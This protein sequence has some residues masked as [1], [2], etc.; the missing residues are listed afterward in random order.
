[1]L[2]ELSANLLATRIFEA[3][4][5]VTGFCRECKR[6]KFQMCEKKTAN[7]IFRNG[8]C[9]FRK[10]TRNPD[11]YTDQMT[12]DAEY[13]TLRREATVSVPKDVDPVAYCPLLCAGVTCFN[14]LRQQNITAGELVAVQGIGGLGHL[15][16]QYAAKLGYRVVVLSRGKDK[17]A[18][19]RELGASEYIDTSNSTGVQELLA[20]GGAACILTTAPNADAVAPLISGLQAGGR[21]LILGA[22]GVVPFNTLEMLHKAISIQGWPS[23]H[24]LDSEETFQFSR[25]HGINCMVE[26]YPLE[27]AN[28][29][30]KDMM[31]GKPRFRAVIK[32]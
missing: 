1:M 16:I 15:A 22:A 25:H 23:G 2:I 4:T 31:A 19:A 11:E 9:E 21:L 18:F 32:I 14:G 13:M 3:D 27:E 10:P 30:L 29:A 24:P 20:M 5:G 8:G 28:K 26:T 6:G 17:E 7:G 12:L